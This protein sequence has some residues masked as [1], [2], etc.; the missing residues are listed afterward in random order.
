[1]LLDRRQPFASGRAGTSG[2]GQQV[3][4]GRTKEILKG[5]RRVQTEG[6]QARGKEAAVG[7]LN[8]RRCL[9]QLKGLLDNNRCTGLMRHDPNSTR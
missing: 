1:M 4:G 6:R 5:Q 9:L 7:P 8:S 2:E 3:G